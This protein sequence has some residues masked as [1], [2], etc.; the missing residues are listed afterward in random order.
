MEYIFYAVLLFTF[1]TIG[2]IAFTS[3]DDLEEF[4]KSK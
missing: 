1:G 4:E 2:Y 3:I